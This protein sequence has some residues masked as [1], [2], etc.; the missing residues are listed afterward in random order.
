[1][2]LDFDVTKVK[3]SWKRTTLYRDNEG[4][5]YEEA[6]CHEDEKGKSYWVA[7][8]DDFKEVTPIWHPITEAIVW[9]AM[10]VGMSSVNEDN[11]AEFYARSRMLDRMSDS[12]PLV[13]KGEKTMITVQMLKDHIGL[14]TNVSNETRAAWLKRVANFEFDAFYRQAER[15][16]KKEEVTA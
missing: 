3:D 16:M 15:D 4:N 11:I 6:D 1:M 13:I 5:Q 2:S 12:L 7:D 14:T 8:G 10:A 9:R